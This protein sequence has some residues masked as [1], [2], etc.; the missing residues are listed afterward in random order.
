MGEESRFEGRLIV[1]RAFWRLACVVEKGSL[2]GV[3]RKM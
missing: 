1:D 3:L 2:T